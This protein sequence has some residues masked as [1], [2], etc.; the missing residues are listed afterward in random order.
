MKPWHVFMEVLVFLKGNPQIVA[1]TAAC[2]SAFMAYI[3]WSYSHEIFRAAPAL[4]ETNAAIVVKDPNSVDID[5]KFKIKNTGKERF[6]ITDI[7]VFRV[8]FQGRAHERVGQ[9]PVLNP[10]HPDCSFN[11]GIK[12][13][14]TDNGKRGS[15]AG[16]KKELEEKLPGLIGK[17][18]LILRIVYEVS[19]KP[20][21][22]KYFLGYSYPVVS[23]LTEAE[24]G[25]IKDYLPYEFQVDR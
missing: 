12:L 7:N 25:E 22:M 13:S 5:F 24:Y 14:F 9:N 23:L 4:Y 17:Q 19:G 8:D 3:T 10:I 2:I 11:Y 20:A 15:F 21:V 16:D 6:T 18:A 1:A